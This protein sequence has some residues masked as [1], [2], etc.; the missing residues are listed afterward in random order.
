M[1]KLY[2][3]YYDYILKEKRVSK[4]KE[5]V[6]S[7]I[8]DLTDRRGIGNEFEQIDEDIKEELIGTWI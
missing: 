7:I 4:S 5:I 2:E 6:F 8:H 1:E 3:E